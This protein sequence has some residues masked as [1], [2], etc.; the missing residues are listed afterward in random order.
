MKKTE[1]IAMSLWSLIYPARC[2]FC[3]G[4]M[5]MRQ[6]VCEK[7]RGK[8]KP[9]SGPTCQKCGK[10]VEEDQVFCH[11]CRKKE[12][13]FNQGFSLFQYEDIR[14]SLYRF[15]YSGR[16]EYAR[17]Y[18]EAAYRFY[19]T[20]LEA[21]HADALVPVPLHFRKQ[22]KRGYNQAEEF[23]TALSKLT[24]IPVEKH[25]V[26]RIK[27]TKPMKTVQGLQ[28]QNNLKSAFLI[29]GNDVKLK[30]IIIIDD[31]YTTG[32]TIDAVS[33]VCRQAGIEKIYFLTVAVGNGM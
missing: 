12:H 15:K 22:L 30:T 8:V 27:N 21:L 5:H 2:P 25:F 24:G 14:E 1:I 7:C 4:A 6:L 16:A 33:R 28:R 32:A 10:K 31:I 3:D 26:K 20:K 18:G 9:L 11:D 19:G 13:N 29:T 17:F 23:A